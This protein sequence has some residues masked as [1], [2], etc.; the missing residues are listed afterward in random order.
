MGAVLLAKKRKIKRYC[1]VE[2]ITISYIKKECNQTDVFTI[3]RSKY[4][5][6]NDN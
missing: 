6:V 1:F 4:E 3:T 2:Y 5:L